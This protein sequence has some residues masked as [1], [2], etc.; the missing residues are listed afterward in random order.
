VSREFVAAAKEVESGR[1][2]EEEVVVA[3]VVADVGLGCWRWAWLWWSRLV[4]G[5][6]APLLPLLVFECS[7]DSR[8]VCV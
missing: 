1:E 6:G 4:V 3:V 8:C 7:R 5:E 2:F